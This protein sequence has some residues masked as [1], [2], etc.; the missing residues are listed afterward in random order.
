LK[1]KKDTHRVIVGCSHGGLAAL[2]QIHRFDPEGKTYIL[3]RENELP[4]SPTSLGAFIGGQMSLNKL[5]FRDWDYFRQMNAKYIPDQE[6]EEIDTVNKE[7]VCS[8]GT[9]IVFD[10]LLIAT[11]ARPTIPSIDGIDHEKVFTVRNLENAKNLQKV[12]RS[13]KN[14]LIIGAGLIGMEIAAALSKRGLRVTVIE[15]LGQALPLYF[16]VDTSDI[17]TAIYQ[18]NGVEIFTNTKV[19]GMEGTSREIKVS[20]DSGKDING[21]FV[22][23]ATGVTPNIQFLQGSGIELGKGILIDRHLET[24]KPGIYAV[25]DVAEGEGF[26]DEKKSINP[27]VFNAAF[28]GKIA[29]SN[30][31]GKIKEFPGGLN[32]N[33]FNFFNNVAFSIGQFNGEES[34]TQVLKSIKAETLQVKKLVIKD[35]YLVGCTVLNYPVEPGILYQAI[36]KKWD[37][38]EMVLSFEDDFVNGVRSTFIKESQAEIEQRR[39]K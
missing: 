20:L 6:V 26:F 16:D 33:I 19:I 25:G 31:T 27:T 1:S 10:Q 15:L 36:F 13:S 35:N 12:A 18:K 38:E 8:D 29:G 28:Q 23:V 22:V 37:P 34:G 17:I 24:N 39:E 3:S 5:F 14:C 30:M 11:G 9:R 21:D 2:E 32:M 4:Y 7:I